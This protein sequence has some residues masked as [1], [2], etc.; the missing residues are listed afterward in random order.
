MM[1]LQNIMQSRRRQLGMSVIAHACNL[2]MQDCEIK[3]GRPCLKIKGKN[4]D[5]WE[6]QLSDRVLVKH[7]QDPGCNAQQQSRE[8]GK[9][10]VAAVITT[11]VQRSYI[12]S[13]HL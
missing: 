9:G 1:S 4:K 6:V 8:G 5:G 11:S 12:I 3:D 13:V 10:E 7:T 2:S